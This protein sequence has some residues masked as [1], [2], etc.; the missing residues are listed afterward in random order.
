[1]RDDRRGLI[2]G[3]AGRNILSL[4]RL[5][6]LDLRRSALHQTSGCP[7]VNVAVDSPSVSETFSHSGLVT[8][9]H[10]SEPRI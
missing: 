5:M 2:T 7:G 1:M 4:S 8:V 6:M 10:E 3:G 9:K